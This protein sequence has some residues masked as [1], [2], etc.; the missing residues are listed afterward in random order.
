MD[1]ELKTLAFNKSENDA[2]YN[3]LE[4]YLRA[5]YIDTSAVFYPLMV[6]IVL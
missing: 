6:K 5:S 2:M 1:S 3:P 4:Y